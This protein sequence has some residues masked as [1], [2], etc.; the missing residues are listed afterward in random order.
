MTRQAPANA[1]LRPRNYPESREPGE[2]AVMRHQRHADVLANPSIG[3]LKKGDFRTQ[4][5]SE[6]YERINHVS[7][8]R[9]I[10]QSV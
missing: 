8:G 2:I 6:V 5:V 1:R 9:K 7:D 3:E 10:D 4:A